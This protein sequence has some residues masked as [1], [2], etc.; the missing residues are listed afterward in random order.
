MNLQGE[1]FHVINRVLDQA[2][3]LALQT[4]ATQQALQG[5]ETPRRISGVCRARSTHATQ[6]YFASNTG[7]R[8]DFHGPQR[9]RRDRANVKNIGPQ[10]ETLQALVEKIIEENTN[11]RTET[12][13]EIGA[14]GF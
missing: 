4:Y 3:G 5:P 8:A 10:R 2:I 13:I 6:C 9:P 12:G 7:A 1:P 11:L 14:A